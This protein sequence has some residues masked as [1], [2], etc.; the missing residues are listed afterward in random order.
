MPTA[1]AS[2]DAGLAAVVEAAPVGVLV[3][4][5]DG[6]MLYVNSALESMFGYSKAQLLGQKVEMLLP[7]EIR[8]RHLD[9]R[10]LFFA[11]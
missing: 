9:F 8:E 2:D 11:Q 4:A 10:Q 3:V 7:A 6:R 1:G 5:A